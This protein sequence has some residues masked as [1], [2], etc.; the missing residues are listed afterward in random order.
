MIVRA[1][2]IGVAI[3]Q[4]VRPGRHWSEEERQ[5]VKRVPLR[6]DPQWR[7]SMLVVAILAA[8]GTIFI[9][10]VPARYEPAF[11]FLLYAGIAP[12]ELWIRKGR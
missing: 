10:F 8:A 2:L 6:S 3:Q 9:A 5:A 7:R 11:V 1:A 4:A 12:L